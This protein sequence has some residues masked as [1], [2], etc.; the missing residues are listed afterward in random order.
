MSSWAGP[1]G[2]HVEV[3]DGYVGFCSATSNAAQRARHFREEA[4]FW[5]VIGNQVDQAVSKYYSLALIA[6]RTT[7]IRNDYLNIPA[8]WA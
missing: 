4:D 6:P 8:L 3:A 5:A 7:R 1:F 2:G